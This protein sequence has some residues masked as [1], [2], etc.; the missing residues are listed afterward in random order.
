MRRAGKLGELLPGVLPPLLFGAAA[1]A[2]GAAS[3]LLF[4]PGRVAPHRIS[5]ELHRVEHLL[6]E[7]RKLLEA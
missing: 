5:I 3:A 6:A 7:E 4:G 1:I 2:A